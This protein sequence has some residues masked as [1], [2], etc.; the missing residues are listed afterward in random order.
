MPAV[1]HAA[2][3][4]TR[5]IQL[6]GAFLTA[7]VA[8]GGLFHLAMTP[9]TPKIYEP[10]AADVCT[11]D[12]FCDPY[13]VK[14]G[15]RQGDQLSLASPVGKALKTMAATGNVPDAQVHELM[16]AMDQNLNFAKSRATLEE[17]EGMAFIRP[18]QAKAN[19]SAPY[20]ARNNPYLKSEFDMVVLVRGMNGECASFAMRPDGSFNRIEEL[21]KRTASH[22]GISSEE[23]KEKTDRYMSVMNG[24]SV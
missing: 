12:R 1:N 23:C 20:N 21:K 6:T 7:T 16:S 11:S 10:T 4:T 13:Q 9:T 17:V 5:N 15:M 3:Q 2:K 22:G 19:P 8:A 18:P 24:M 14:M